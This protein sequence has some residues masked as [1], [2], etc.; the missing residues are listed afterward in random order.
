MTTEETYR[1]GIEADTSA[2]DK[3]L[4][5]MTAKADAFGAAFSGALKGA[6][7]GTQSLDTVLRQLALRLSTIALNAALKPVTDAAGGLFGQLAG[8]LG[9]LFGG[10]GA[11]SGQV[12]PFAKGGV[13]A[14][15]SYF[16]SGRRIG[17]M[18]EAGAEAILPLRRGPDG[19]LGVA[20]GPGRGGT[21]GI[22]FNVTTA[23]AASFRRSEAQIQAMLARA[24]ERGRRGL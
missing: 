17:L 21:G 10:G 4:G 22:V 5:D 8:G 20:A 9:A 18:G 19:T 15:P 24:A 3:A 23:D 11:A 12:Q 7:A 6:V 16:P 14:S 1:I 2:F 13:V